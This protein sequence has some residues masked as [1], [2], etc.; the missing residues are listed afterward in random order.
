[1]GN[2][3]STKELEIREQVDKA[4]E[5]LMAINRPKPWPAGASVGLLV[6]MMILILMVSLVLFIWVDRTME[7]QVWSTVVV[8]SLGAVIMALGAFFS[9]AS[10]F[11]WFPSRDP[12]LNAKQASY[13]Y[14]WGWLSM[15]LQ[16]GGVSLMGYAL[17]GMYDT[18]LRP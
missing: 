11:D 12:K 3:N 10:M 6:F 13:S 4:A 9:A 17:F 8:M 1:M 15:F 2:S 16:L 7:G 5:N 14:T 18:T